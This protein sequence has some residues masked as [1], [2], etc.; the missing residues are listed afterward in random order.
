M[1]GEP[2]S[3]EDWA[4]GWFCLRA[5]PRME[6]V[7]AAT[8]ATLDSVEVFLPRTIRPK[9]AAPTLIKPLF[10]G[11]LFVSLAMGEDDPAP[12]RSTMGCIGLVR[13]G[14]VYTPLPA[15]FVENL[16]ALARENTQPQALFKSGDKVK[17]TAGP[18]AGLEAV[19]DMA[20]GEDRARVL[21][22][23]LGTVQRLTVD[24]GALDN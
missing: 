13:L 1:T 15:A 6:A 18:F 10:P 2:D 12:I 7:A 17:L 21:L 19:Y 8:L 3:L 5:K 4:K 11:Y 9:K 14:A 20:K 16:E 22:E 23:V 24:V